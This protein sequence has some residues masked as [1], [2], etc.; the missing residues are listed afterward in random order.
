MS[1]GRWRQPIKPPPDV[2]E[3][4][5]TAHGMLTGGDPTPL[6][7]PLGEPWPSLAP[8]KAHPVTLKGHLKQKRIVKNISINALQRKSLDRH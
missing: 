6:L 1:L 4:C 2:A 3:L 7:A 5:P 8:Q